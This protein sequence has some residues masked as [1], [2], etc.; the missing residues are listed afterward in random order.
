MGRGYEVDS[1]VC[2]DGAGRF[3]VIAFIDAPR[4]IRKILEHLQHARKS[5]L[6]YSK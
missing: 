1:L 6:T 4:T 5:T 2:P 3:Q